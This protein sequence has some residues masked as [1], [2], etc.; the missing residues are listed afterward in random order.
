MSENYKGTIVKISNIRKHDNA[1][2]LQCTN[3]F[4]NNVVVGLNTQIGDLGI[5]FPVETALSA[6]FMY[7]N[8]LSTNS[9][10]NKDKTSKGYFGSHG[11]VKAQTF[12]GEKS[13]GF[14]LPINSLNYLNVPH[15]TLKE[16]FELDEWNGHRICSKYIPRNT[17]TPGTGKRNLGKTYKKKESKIIPGQFKF[18]YDT[19]QLG[20]NI[21]RIQPNDIISISWKMHGTS[22]IA[23]NIL[24]K[25][26][27]S[28]TLRFFSWLSEKIA[29]KP[30]YNDTYQYVYASRKVV[31][32]EFIEDKKHY[33]SYDLWTEVGKEQFEGKLH[34]G[35]S[36]Y[37]EIVGYTK[38][39]G[40]I[41]KGFDYKCEPY[42]YKVYVYRI[43]NTSIDGLNTIDLSWGQLKERCKELGVDHA[44]EIY[45][46]KAKEIGVFTGDEPGN[47][48]EEK[49]QGYLLNY[50][51]EVYVHDQDSQFCNNKVPEEGIVVRKEGLILEAY[52]L[53][54]FRFLEY[55]SKQLDENI[56]DIETS[57]SEALDELA[58]QAQE[59]NMGYDN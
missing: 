39:G 35:E 37:Y 9:E 30:M 22:A 32:N 38:D 40:M 18:H 7:E 56:V 55:E 53:K 45:Y 43:T 12:R 1:D 33:Y 44:P 41:Q 21:H 10:L 24:C 13:M 28:K 14:W 34:R 48:I 59:L 27:R 57:Q 52:K 26:P 11:R 29:K 23:A 20:K 36:V 15:E 17:T 19:A 2:R 4:G 16:G 46:G 6:G 31:K 58:E 25:N 5:F 50:L 47:T 8:N 49:F 42:T 54:S 3:I 51:Q